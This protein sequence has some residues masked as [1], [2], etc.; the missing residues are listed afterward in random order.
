MVTRLTYALNHG[1]GVVTRIVVRLSD[2]NGPRGGEGGVLLILF[3]LWMGTLIR[4]G[5]VARGADTSNATPDTPP[6]WRFLLLGVVGLAALVVAGRLFV[7]GATGIATAFGVNAYTVGALVVAIGTSLPELVTVLLARLR[8]HDD[9]GVGTLLG[10]NLFNSMAI[11]GVAA[12]IHPITAS[13][14]EV[15]AALGM[16]VFSLLL[17]PGRAGVIGRSRGV[18]LLA[19]AVLAGAVG[20]LLRQDRDA[21]PNQMTARRVYCLGRRFAVDGEGYSGA[22]EI[23]PEDGQPPPE[24]APLQARGHVVAMTGD[25]VNARAEFGTAFN[26]QF[27][28]NGKL[29]LALVG[30]VGLQIVAVHWAPAQAV[31]DT[32]ALSLTDWLLATAIASSTLL[33]EEIRKLLHAV[34]RR[35]L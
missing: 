17:I 15:A 29:W 19:A 8:G 13:P 31:F 16:G 27:F 7:S 1:R 22:G 5:L 24:W 30:V 20:D 32:V 11:V 10:S 12:T 9:V 6:V 18:M 2:V 21:D 3:I 26:R 4:S 28:T 34:G 25:G 23:T 35:F 14:M 33:L